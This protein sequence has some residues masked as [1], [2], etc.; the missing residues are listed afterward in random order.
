MPMKTKSNSTIYHLLF[1]SKKAVAADIV[2]DMATNSHIEWADAT[3]NPVTGCSKIS[4]G[5][6][7]C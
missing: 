7:Q 2:N 6:K 5:R 3:W 4:P 1:A